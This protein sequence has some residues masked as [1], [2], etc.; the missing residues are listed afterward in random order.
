[1]KHAL[2]AIALALTV[3][4]AQAQAPQ[5]T[6]VPSSPPGLSLQ[7]TPPVKDRAT[8]Y[9]NMLGDMAAGAMS[10]R[11]AGMSKTSVVADLNAKA[12]TFPKDPFVASIISFQRELIDMAYDKFAVE[13]DDVQGVFLA[14]A[15]RRTITKRCEAEFVRVASTF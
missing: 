12:K 2:T 9:C 5:Y 11:Q 7:S 1:M 13:T 15:F 3:T 14:A 8:S 6:P 10:A 4:S